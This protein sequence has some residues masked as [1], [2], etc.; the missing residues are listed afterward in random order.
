MSTPDSLPPFSERLA[1][2]R[3]RLAAAAAS[4]G[5]RPEDVR[6]VAVTK[7][8][9]VE[10]VREALSAGLV[11]LGENKIQEARAKIPE[12]GAGRWHWIGHLQTNKVKFAVE[13]FDEIDAVDSLRLAEEINRRAEEAARHLAV[14]L[15]VNVAGESQKYGL[16]PGE[17]AAVAEQVN[18]LSHLEL[19]G[20][21][22]LAPLV[23][24]PEQA[25]PA[26]A[27]LRECRD[28]VETAT[29]LKLPELSMG[30]SGDFEVAVEE[31]ATSVRL[32]TALFGP[33]EKKKRAAPEAW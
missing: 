17:V 12:V 26:F 23:P 27:G 18:A 32:G 31:G 19:C 20:L 14:L 8:R 16:A 10:T 30:M 33:R 22:T 7:T 2:V 1:D 15:Q 25:R 5:R 9:S 28:R 21:M 4:S 3:A 13:L 24:Q 29:G 6:L 11:D